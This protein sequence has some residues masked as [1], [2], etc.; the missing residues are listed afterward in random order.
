M[1]LSDKCPGMNFSSEWVNGTVGGTCK[2]ALAKKI[3]KHRDSASHQRAIE[4]AQQKQK[5]VLPKA[6]LEMNAALVQETISSFRTAYTVAKE[7]L[8]FR[9]MPPL[10]TLQELNGAVVGNVHRSDHSCAEM[11][12]HIAKEMKQVLVKNIKEKKSRISLTVDESTIFGLAYLIIFIRCDVTGHGGVEN[13]FLDLVELKEGT[14]ASAIY[15]ALRQSLKTAGLD[16]AFLQKNL[17]SIATDGA[18][19]L[20]GCKSGVIARFKTEF[21]KLKSIH[22][23]AHR[24]ELAVHDSLKSLA[25]CN[26]FEIFIS[27]LY[28][29]FNQSHKLARLLQ[30]V[31]DELNVQILK[32][33][34]I[35]TIRW[36]ASS[37]NT[38][39]AVWKNYPALARLFQIESENSA[40]SDKVRK[41]FLGLLKYLSNASFVHDL[42]CMKDV[43][44]ELQSLS[45]KLQKRET[46][47]V[48]SYHHVKQTTEILNAMKS[49]GGKSAAKA[50]Q[51]LS[52]GVFKGVNI[53]GDRAG[54]INSQQ[55]YQ[56]VVDNLTARMPA[57]DLICIL[58]PL[59]KSSWPEN[60]EELVLYGETE[61][62]TLA[63]L[64]GEPGREAVEEFRAYKLQGTQQGA[65]LKQLLIAS[66]TYLATS[67]ECERG[68]SAVNDTDRKTRNKL[69]A[70]SMSSLLFVDLNGPPLEVFNP[71]P[72]VM[73][74]VK[75][76]H[77][78]SKS[79]VPGRKAKEGK[80]RP[81]WSMF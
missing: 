19:V 13:I 9:K 33:G 11:V 51:G 7:R 74:W 16:D 78:L 80:P 35:F 18:S 4:I 45:L 81:L 29:L 39:R 65:T 54:K 40:N 17:I 79:W 71:A 49:Q 69:R 1:L 5:E 38:V 10:M 28:S 30:E 64:L 57:D 47:I 36:V 12:N 72:Y 53:V 26:H 50:Q 55:F 44:R 23:M 21:P 31:A 15:D 73:S 76:G 46:T 42:A 68:F 3:Y 20:T 66:H 43:L 48:Q 37:F 8:A 63:K 59:D 14:D 77:R 56:A 52:V 34:E 22:C 6:V 70:K 41:K 75:A 2:R 25:A 60:R 58:Q 61:V 62:H 24:L 27:K 67:A 32:I